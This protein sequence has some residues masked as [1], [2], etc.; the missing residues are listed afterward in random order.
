MKVRPFTPYHWKHLS[1]KIIVWILGH[2]LV[3]WRHFFPTA[4]LR[5]RSDAGRGVW[6][7]PTRH[8]PGTNQYRLYNYQSKFQLCCHCHIKLDSFEIVR[9]RLK[10]SERNWNC[11]ISS[12]S[13]YDRTRMQSKGNADETRIVC[14]S[15]GGMYVVNLK[16]IDRLRCPEPC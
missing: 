15:A 12:S 16:F 8:T 9:L 1:R 14:L 7:I 4:Q 13:Y 2:R 5:T 3:R 11:S 10:M 6:N